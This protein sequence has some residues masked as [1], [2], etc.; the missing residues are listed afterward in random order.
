[1][2]KLKKAVQLESLQQPFKTALRTAAQ[3]G[4]DA[5]EV[6]GRT[7]VRAAEMSRTAIRHL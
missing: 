6:N 2:L 3:M 5:V 1:M 4:A 7:E